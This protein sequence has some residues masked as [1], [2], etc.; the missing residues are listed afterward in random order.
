MVEEQRKARLYQDLAMEIALTLLGAPINQLG[1]LRLIG[2][3]GRGLV[4]AAA[5]SMSK[6]TAKNIIANIPKSA[7]VNA[8]K[9][10]AISGTKRKK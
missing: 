3:G 8:A 6:K 7:A 10:V 9:Y 4:G 2:K 5:S 1:R